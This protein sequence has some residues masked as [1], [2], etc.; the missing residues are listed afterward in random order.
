MSDNLINWSEVSREL[1]G[2]RTQITSEYDGKK[3]KKQITGLKRLI[4]FWIKWIK[5]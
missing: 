2:N 4:N 3:Y 5:K 1:T